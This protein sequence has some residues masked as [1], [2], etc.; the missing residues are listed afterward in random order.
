MILVK[1]CAAYAWTWTIRNVIIVHTLVTSELEFSLMFGQRL[2][3]EIKRHR[4]EDLTQSLRLM[5]W[6]PRRQNKD[7][8]NSTQKHKT[9]KGP[10]SDLYHPLHHFLL[11]YY[12]LYSSSQLHSGPPP[13]YNKRLKHFEA[14]SK[15]Q[16][17]SSSWSHRRPD[18]LNFKVFKSSNLK[19]LTT[20][21]LI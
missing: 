18:G 13:F 8:V 1:V 12:T 6:S 10:N 20:D 9:K 19:G 21:Q 14:L 15:I 2:N 5:W 16:S 17:V 7:Q 4:G 11:T 3:S